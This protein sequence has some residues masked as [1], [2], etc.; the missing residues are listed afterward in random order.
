MKELNI[1][2]CGVGG[3]GIGL[4]AEVMLK[5]CHKAGYD[6]KGVDTHGLAQR[7]GTVVS[8]LRIG[9]KIHTPLIPSGKADLIIALERLEALRAV[10]EM[11]NEGGR[12]IY[13]DAEYQTI[14]NRLG[15][16]IY[17]SSI[18]LEKA[19]K[20]KNGEIIRVFE[21]K[22][23]D[24]RMQNT[25]LINK[26]IKSCWIEKF[27]KELA[28]ESLGELMQGKALERNIELLNS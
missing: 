22:L 4:L 15:K 1:Y 28:A 20:E 13:Y 8:H 12:I 3:Q 6:V 5:T 23:S 16:F 19:V 2:M 11:L 24:P 25:I 17:P 26:I 7:G 21:D 27:T 18:E 10:N 9:K 14:G